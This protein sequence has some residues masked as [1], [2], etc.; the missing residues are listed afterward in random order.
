MVQIPGLI[1]YARG[2]HDEF[3]GQTEAIVTPAVVVEEPEKS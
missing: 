2:V 3:I 1:S